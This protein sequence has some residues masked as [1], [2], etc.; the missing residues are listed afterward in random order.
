MTLVE[1]GDSGM[2]LLLGGFGDASGFYNGISIEGNFWDSEEI[3]G[4]SAGVITFHRGSAEVFHSR[5][6]KNH[7]NSCR[8]IKDYGY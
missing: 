7:R 6:G 4:N 5:I 8:C 1:G 2:D 3:S